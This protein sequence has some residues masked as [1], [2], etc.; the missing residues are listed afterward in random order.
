MCNAC[1][2]FCSGPTI[3][4]LLWLFNASLSRSAFIFE[5]I[6]HMGVR[7]SE[8]YKLDLIVQASPWDPFTELLFDIKLHKGVIRNRC[9]YLCGLYYG[10][11]IHPLQ[12]KIVFWMRCDG[13]NSSQF[14][15]LAR[16]CSFTTAIL[17]C[18]HYSCKVKAFPSIFES[19]K[20]IR[21]FTRK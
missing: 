18:R 4:S 17:S 8:S 19:W 11:A 14:S 5:Y 21:K 20:I 13:G 1:F 10:D 16:L 12:K 6:L 3:P 9:L 15:E 7:S 2:V